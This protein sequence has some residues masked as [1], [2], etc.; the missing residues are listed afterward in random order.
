M[1]DTVTICYAPANSVQFRAEFRWF[2]SQQHEFPLQLN[3][4]PA[5]CTNM[6]ITPVL[7]IQLYSARPL[8]LPIWIRSSGRHLLH[9]LLEDSRELLKDILTGV[10][11]GVRVKP[12]CTKF[13]R[14]GQEKF[15]N[16]SVLPKKVFGSCR[17]SR[18]RS[19]LHNQRGEHC[20][21]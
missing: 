17:S 6:V 4:S 7:S 8:V 14:P 1:P 15:A 20:H 10:N 2:S 11:L 9:A 16:S 19:V 13:K 21:D 5:M 3:G 12:I 18:F